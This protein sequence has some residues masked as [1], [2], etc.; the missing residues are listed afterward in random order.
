[1]AL[2]IF[3]GNIEYIDQ[4]LYVFENVLSLTLEKLLHEKI[5]TSTIPYGQH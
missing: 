1:M 5:L 3:T 4:H 2:K